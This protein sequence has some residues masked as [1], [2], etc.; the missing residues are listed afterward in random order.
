[1]HGLEHVPIG[2][3]IEM[4][5]EESV[6]SVD[7]NVPWVTGRYFGEEVIRVSDKDWG[8]ILWHLGME[9]NL[10]RLGHARYRFYAEVSEGCDIPGIL[11]G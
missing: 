7:K 3:E 6:M 8:T 11:V 2:D 10:R 5:S 1:M 9:E 4:L